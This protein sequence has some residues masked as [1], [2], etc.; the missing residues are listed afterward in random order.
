MRST[1]SVPHVKTLKMRIHKTVGSNVT[2]CF[3]WLR[4]MITL[5]TGVSEQDFEDNMWVLAKECNDGIN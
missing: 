4:N 3:I 1:F 2:C 5:I